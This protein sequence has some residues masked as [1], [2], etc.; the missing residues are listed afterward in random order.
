M[1]LAPT[2]N[3]NLM[4]HVMSNK[5]TPKRP[6]AY[7]EAFIFAMFNENL[8]PAGVEQHFGL[9]YPNKQPVYPLF[10]NSQWS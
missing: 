7:I 4:K 3:Q 1:N 9:F 6:N 8:K 5:G 2:Y 10:T